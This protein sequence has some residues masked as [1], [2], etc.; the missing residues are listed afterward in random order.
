MLKDV[1]K[2]SDNRLKLIIKYYYIHQRNF[3]LLREILQLRPLIT[4]LNMT[5]YQKHNILLKRS[6]HKKLNSLMMLVFV[7]NNHINQTLVTRV[8]LIN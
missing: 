2:A 6:N 1:R 3:S 4:S 7:S 8:F 5:L